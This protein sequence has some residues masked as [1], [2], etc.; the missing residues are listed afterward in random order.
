VNA[1]NSEAKKALLDL[2]VYT[3]V[4]SGDGYWMAQPGITVRISRYEITYRGTKGS[5]VNRDYWL[6]GFRA[7]QFFSLN[8]FGPEPLPFW[9]TDGGVERDVL[10]VFKN[11]L[12]QHF[13]ADDI[14]L[15]WSEQGMQGD[16]YWNFDATALWRYE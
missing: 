8:V 2:S 4:A 3:V 10:A 11:D 13:G 16:D 6:A 9:Y 5:E 15:C 12:R 7:Q 14:K 1:E